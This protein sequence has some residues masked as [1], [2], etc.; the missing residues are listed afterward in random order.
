MIS[1]DNYLHTLGFPGCKDLVKN[2]YGQNYLKKITKIGNIKYDHQEIRKFCEISPDFCGIL[3]DK[4]IKQTPI[5]TMAEEIANRTKP[6]MRYISLT[7]DQIM[8]LLNY[9]LELISIILIPVITYFKDKQR[10]IKV[11]DDK[12]IGIIDFM[13]D[14]S[15]YELKCQHRYDFTDHAFA[16]LITYNKLLKNTHN[17]RIFNVITGNI[18]EI[19]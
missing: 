4:I 7:V 13:D 6:G 2:K 16:Q 8:Q 19:K 1:V 10:D 9:D 18:H 14:E 5:N 3:I 15:I 17:L 11:S 12:L